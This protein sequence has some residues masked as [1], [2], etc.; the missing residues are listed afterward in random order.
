MAAEGGVNAES[1]QLNAEG[2]NSSCRFASGVALIY[3]APALAES[4]RRENSRRGTKS[5]GVSQRHPESLSLLSEV[6]LCGKAGVL[7]DE[8]RAPRRLPD[9]I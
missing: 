5:A 6:S 8:F 1:Q 3:V 4:R 9:G 2:K 7:G